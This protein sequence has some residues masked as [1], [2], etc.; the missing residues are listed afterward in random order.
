LRLDFQRHTAENVFGSLI[1][2][3]TE[4]KMSSEVWFQQN[5]RSS[6]LSA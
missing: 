3:D 5:I 2:E 6:W 1:P 4:Q